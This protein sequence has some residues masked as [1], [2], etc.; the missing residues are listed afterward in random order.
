[1]NNVISRV[2][3]SSLSLFFLFTFSLYAQ[4]KTIN[5]RVVNSQDG[6]GVSGASI[7]VKGTSRAVSA[8]DNGQFTITVPASATTLTVSSAGYVAQD[9]PVGTSLNPVFSL[10]PDV[11]A[12]EDVVVIG[13]GTRSKKNITGS[14][15]KVDAAQVRDMPFASPDQLLQ[16]KASGVQ[17]SSMSGTPGG[18]VTVRVRGTS[19]F[20]PGSPA[21]Q[22]LYII[23]GV[24]VNNTPLGP[25]GLGVE[26]Q[27]SNP[28]AD[29]NPADIQSMEIL[30]DANSTSI[31]G[32]RGA[33][34]VIIITT[35][36]GSYGQKPRVTLNTYYAS[37]KATNVPEV[38]NG[39]QTGELLNEIWV[40]DGK[41]PNA[42]P[43]PNPGSL[44]TYSRLDKIF[45]TAP[46]YNADINVAGG[47]DKT[48]YY[49]GGS[50]YQQEGILKPQ[51]FNR[52]SFRLNLDNYISKRFKIS[53]SNTV[54]RTFR[55]I[56]PNDN[57]VGG[58]LTAVGNSVLY[59]IYNEDGTYFR[60]PVG[61]N[62]IA[63]VNENDQTS[64]GIRYIG[65]IY[66]EWEVIPGMFFRSSWSLDYNDAYNRAF[67]STILNGPGSVADA[68][69]QS[70]RQSTWINEQ[71][72][73][74]GLK[75]SDA[76]QLNFLV[77][78]T[79]QKTTSRF[80][81]VSANNFPN[82]D[83]RNISSAAQSTGWNGDKIQSTLASFF[84]RV[85]YTLN[86][87][88]IFDVNMRGDASSRFGANNQ[89][90]F[91]PSAGVAW[92]VS[93]EDFM[94]GQNTFSDLKLKA[95][96]GLTGS[97]ETIS[98]YASRGL[99]TGND[100]YL[101]I[102]GTVAS[103]IA[104]PDL[105]WEQTKQF[106][107]G[108]EF[109]ILNNR[110]TGEINYYDKFTK[111]VLLNKTIPM[112][113]G[114]STI[115]YNGGDISNKGFEFS[116]NAGIVRGKDFTWDV[117]LNLAHNKNLIEKLDAPYFEPFS[118]K[119][120]LFQEGYPVNGFWLWQQ[121][122][123]DPQTGNAVYTDVD[124]NNVIDDNDRMILGSNQPDLLGG[125]TTNLK[126]K[127]FDLS[128][129]FNFE[130]GQE[131]V[132]WST[133]F[134][135]HGGTRFNAATGMATYGFYTRQLDRWQKP[136]DITDIPKVGG[137]PEE[138]SNNYGRYTSRAMEDGSYTRLKTLTL[139]YSLPA[140]LMSRLGINRARV[141]VMGTNLITITNYSGLDPEI[142][143][144]GGKGTVNGVEMFTVPQPKTIQ[145]GLTV[146]F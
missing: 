36:R 101:G 39:P 140:G 108:V 96:Y 111:G 43:Y 115:A 33:N 87:K 30:K 22:P 9:F 14:V 37:A 1:M 80:F 110:I 64:T 13:Y 122:R 120:I 2:L 129:F 125:L 113:T 137:T 118:R 25:A 142:N 79:V 138:R 55:E 89:W 139:G 53:T 75:L 52:A 81:G 18:G 45:Q 130:W 72:L 66:G 4:D 57:S 51:T 141:Y 100:N 103:Q 92:R 86:N 56:V 133:F 41:D 145:A 99:W 68:Y 42:L 114:F 10:Q 47:N 136:G 8:N 123:V 49:L 58:L 73:R 106:N 62:A 107:I 63:L 11:S 85:D 109:G 23:D 31:Y 16:G 116:V 93:S 35:K 112:T 54:S 48:A 17:I 143:A 59:P 90:G 134:M 74:Y 131:L 119:F 126:Y 60:G 28:L 91:F 67:N 20:S 77:G 104:N 3:F 65:N 40:H 78:N 21:S 127:N 105:K 19:S 61:N 88:Y 135:V 44:P 144:G 95:S 46:T 70:N 84:G 34:G 76:N 29:L 50:Y 94:Q 7:T 102:P 24:F 132:N 128:A 5:G 15:V 6:S 146:T 27:I 69:E 97:Q 38:V 32:S 121:E 71:T 117:N 83:L 124:K 12:Q 98:E 82:D 26:Q